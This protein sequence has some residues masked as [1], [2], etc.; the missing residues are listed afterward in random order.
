MD[1]VK[2]F[3][4]APLSAPIVGFAS[5][6]RLLHKIHNTIII[7]ASLKRGIHFAGCPFYCSDSFSFSLLIIFL[8]FNLLLSGLNCCLHRMVC[9]VFQYFLFKMSTLTKLT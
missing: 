2:V 9:V 7:A 8:Y 4:V 6:Q 1:M 3:C 5:Y